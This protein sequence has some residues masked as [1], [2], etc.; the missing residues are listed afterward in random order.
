M[1]IIT[2]IYIIREKN[3]YVYL[4]ITP[5]RTSV[6]IILTILESR[7]KFLPTLCDLSY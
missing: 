1:C 5:E 4:I 7:F 3:T 2:K 6:L